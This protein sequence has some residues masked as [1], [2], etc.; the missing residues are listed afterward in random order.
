MLHVGLACDDSGA[1]GVA[2]IHDEIERELIEAERRL[3][4]DLFRDG[5]L[6]DE[7]RRRIEHDLDLREARLASQRDDE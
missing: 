1:V 7:A 6:K 3:I 2:D 4:N 5:Q